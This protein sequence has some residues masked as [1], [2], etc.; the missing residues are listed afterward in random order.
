[1]N[2]AAVTTAG[3]T[4]IGSVDVSWKIAGTGDFNGD[5]KADI[6]WRNDSGAT[7]IWQMDGANVLSAGLTS[8][9]VVDPSWKIAA[10]IL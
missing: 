10:P 5:S 8:T 4:S 7:S 3:L 9:P 2:G 6:L 1:M